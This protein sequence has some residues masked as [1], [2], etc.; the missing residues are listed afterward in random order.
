MGK[1]VVPERVGNKAKEGVVVNHG[2]CSPTKGEETYALGLDQS[3]VV[4]PGVY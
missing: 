4:V 3:Q 2:M 1:A